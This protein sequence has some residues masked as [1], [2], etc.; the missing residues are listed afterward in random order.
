MTW[1]G[2]PDETVVFTAAGMVAAQARCPI[3]DAISKLIE[4]AD[5]TSRSIPDAARLVIVGS[6]RFDSN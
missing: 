3:E 2:T 1:R 5:A 6:L 4:R